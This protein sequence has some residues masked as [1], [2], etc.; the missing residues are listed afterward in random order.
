MPVCF[1]GGGGSGVVVSVEDWSWVEMAEMADE[2]GFGTGT[3]DGGG[4][5]RFVVL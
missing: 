3:G 5:T 4:D 1:D 2:R